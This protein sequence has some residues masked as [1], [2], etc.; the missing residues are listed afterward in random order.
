VII[1][2]IIGNRFRKEK[3]ISSSSI[4]TNENLVLQEA[5]IPV[6]ITERRDNIVI[7]LMSE[8]ETIKN[9]TQESP[10]VIVESNLINYYQSFYMFD[11]L[12]SA[13]QYHNYKYCKELDY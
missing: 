10:N 3:G 12:I 1:N 9:N 11:L 8:K 6:V 4:E 5:V 13:R 2:L 7:M